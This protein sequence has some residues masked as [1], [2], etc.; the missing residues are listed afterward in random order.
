M[1]FDNTGQATRSRTMRCALL[2]A[3][4]L[5]CVLVGAVRNPHPTKPPI[6]LSAYALPDG[7]VPQICSAMNAVGHVGVHNDICG[8]CCFEKLPGLH[9]PA[10]SDLLPMRGVGKRL[11]S[12]DASFREPA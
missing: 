5:A 4:L 10:E 1:T 8:Q 6:D 9:A 12:A 7:T 2:M 11:T 3:Y